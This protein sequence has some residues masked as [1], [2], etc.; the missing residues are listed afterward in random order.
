MLPTLQTQRLLLRAVEDSDAAA[1]FD[2]FSQEENLLY[3]TRKKAPN[4]DFA[5]NHVQ[6]VQNAVASDTY[7]YWAMQLQE[8][9]TMIGTLCLWNRNEELSTIDIGFEIHPKYK[10]KGLVSEAVQALL[11]YAFV[12]LKYKKIRAVTIIQNLPSIQVLTRNGFKFVSMVPKEEKWQIE[13]GQD[14]A[15]YELEQ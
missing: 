6:N 11:K 3:I 5:D 15:L 14:L 7:L 1:F 9:P 8:D 2:L 12:Q 4:L 13:E 10:G